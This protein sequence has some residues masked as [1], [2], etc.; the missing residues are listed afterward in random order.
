MLDSTVVSVSA[1]VS[2]VSSLAFG[3]HIGT[4]KPMKKQQNAGTCCDAFHRV[5]AGAQDWIDGL[6]LGIRKRT[7]PEPDAH[8]ES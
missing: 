6:V 5:T 7:H 2:L 1:T 4:I 3:I 8:Q